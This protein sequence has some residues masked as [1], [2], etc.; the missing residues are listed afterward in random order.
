MPGEGEQVEC[1]QR[2]RQT[3]IS[4]AEIVFESTAV[5]FHHVEPLFRSTRPAASDD[6]GHVISVHRQAVHPGHGM[7]DAALAIDNLEI[8]PVDRSGILAVAQRNILD[9]AIAANLEDFSIEAWRK[10]SRVGRK[11]TEHQ[12]PG[13]C[14]IDAASSAIMQHSG[15]S[16]PTAPKLASVFVNNIFIEIF[17]CFLVISALQLI[18]QEP[19]MSNFENLVSRNSK[20]RAPVIAER[21]V[22]H[23][24]IPAAGPS[25]DDRWKASTGMS[26]ATERSVA[27]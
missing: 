3:R 18:F 2:H 19:D 21:I 4:V 15:C 10:S 5:I 27:R 20:F 6:F 9:P 23:E 26:W 17:Y 7:F 16:S 13:A 22:R 8:D 12:V 1:G 14:V 11:K 24:G 25:L